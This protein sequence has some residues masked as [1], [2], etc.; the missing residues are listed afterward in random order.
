M[1]LIYFHVFDGSISTSPY[2]LGGGVLGTS[3]LFDIEIRRLPHKC[4]CDQLRVSATFLPYGTPQIGCSCN[5]FRVQAVFI[6][7]F[8]FRKESKYGI[9]GLTFI[10]E[11][12]PPHTFRF[13]IYLAL[14]SNF[15]S[16]LRPLHHSHWGARQFQNM[17]HTAAQLTG[18]FSI[19]LDRNRFKSLFE[20][21]LTARHD[22]WWRSASPSRPCRRLADLA[23]ER[24]EQ[25]NP[26]SV[27]WPPRS[28]RRHP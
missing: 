17:F 4:F 14:L 11:V 16:T 21:I 28:R 26:R 18:E 20:Y 19:I 25:P 15:S 8:S 7:A 1:P 2:L 5:Q 23:Q 10:A 9:Y 27:P 22:A 3:I 24:V 13:S 6:D 12:I